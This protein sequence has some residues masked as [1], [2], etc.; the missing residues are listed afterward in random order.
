MP[1]S[2][3]HLTVHLNSQNTFCFTN[4]NFLSKFLFKKYLVKVSS[5]KDD[6]FI[7]SV[8]LISDRVINK[9][10]SFVIQECNILRR[11]KNTRSSRFSYSLFQKKID[12][13]DMKIII[14]VVMDR[15]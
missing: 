5:T 6:L 8:F 3:L 10:L 9:L 11:V 4:L 1:V 12:G 2:L 7:L 15:Y 14:L 13:I